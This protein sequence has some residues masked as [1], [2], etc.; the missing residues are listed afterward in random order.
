MGKLLPMKLSEVFP[1]NYL[2]ADDLKGNAAV[3]TIASAEIEELGKGNQKDKKLV[4]GFRGKE[5]KLVCNVTNANTIA[6]LYGDDTEGWIGQRI[7]LL[8][9]EVEFQGEM[10]LAIRVSLQKP[11]GA[12]PA[13]APA[14]PVEPDPEPE[15]QP[16]G[17]EEGSQI[18]F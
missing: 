15:F 9:R 4:L 11:A 13:K 17:E 18:P 1:S 3:V 2:K 7:T 10:V 14:K 6:K 12:A 16:G 5:K 8:P